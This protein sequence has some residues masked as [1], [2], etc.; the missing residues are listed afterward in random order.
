M[1]HLRRTRLRVNAGRLRQRRPGAP[2]HL[3]R[4]PPK[5]DLAPGWLNHA[6]PNVI[7][8]QRGIAFGCEDEG[9]RLFG[10]VGQRSLRI[11]VLL[12]TGR[13][14]CP[15]SRKI[16]LRR[17]DATLVNAAINLR[18]IFV[19]VRPAERQYFA[20]PHPNQEG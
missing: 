2:H 8:P 20:G 9:I 11:Y 19:N 6:V 5:P 16:C 17:I 7:T 10:V 12:N 15:A 14:G 13:K 3:E 18:M 4:R 1:A